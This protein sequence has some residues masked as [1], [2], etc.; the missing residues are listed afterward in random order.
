[1]YPVDNYCIIVTAYNIIF[2]FVYYEQYP[3]ACTFVDALIQNK[4]TIDRVCFR[5][6]EICYNGY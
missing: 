6:K 1:M 4:R 3:I 5:F 2:K